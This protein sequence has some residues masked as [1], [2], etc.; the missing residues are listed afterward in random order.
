MFDEYITTAF[1]LVK[2]LKEVLV[3]AL[4]EYAKRCCWIVL[5]EKIV[6]LLIMAIEYPRCALDMNEI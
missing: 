2:A 6:A 3:K 4:K 1:S 5:R